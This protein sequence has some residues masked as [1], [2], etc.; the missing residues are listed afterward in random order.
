M[1]TARPPVAVQLAFKG[2]AS[3]SERA[4]QFSTRGVSPAIVRS[5]F[6]RRWNMA[7]LSGKIVARTVKA[8]AEESS[9]ESAGVAPRAGGRAN[10]ISVGVISN[11]AWETLALMGPIF[12]GD[13][14]D[15]PVS[16]PP[17]LENVP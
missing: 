11:A 16:L 1:L 7:E 13:S 12:T 2:C 4:S 6:G 10:E 5:Q 8:F 14:N 3:A 15:A 17:E 9:A